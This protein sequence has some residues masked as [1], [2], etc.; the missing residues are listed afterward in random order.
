[1]RDVARGITL[2]LTIQAQEGAA[3]IW[4]PDG[5]TVAVSAEGPDHIAN[6]YTLPA[7]GS[8]APQRVAPASSRQLMMS[9]SAAADSVESHATFSPDGRWIA[10]A[11]NQTGRPEVYIRPYPGAEPAIQVSGNGG[12]SPAWSRDGKRLFLSTNRGDRERNDLMVADVT[13]GDAVRVA[14]AE[15][16]ITPW[17]YE[18]TV[19]LRSYDV[20]AD[21]SF[22]AVASVGDSTSLPCRTRY[23]VSDMHVVLNFAEALEA[24]VK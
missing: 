1:M 2:Q 20:L 3:P 24:R 22:L 23:R 15:P 6:V 21:G 5:R 4:S 7:D 8:G 19:Y 18:S 16:F 13:L 12:D 9:W 14:R 10:Y 11:S 17:P